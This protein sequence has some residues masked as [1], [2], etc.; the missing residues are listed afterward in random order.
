MGNTVRPFREESWTIKTTKTKKRKVVRHISADMEGRKLEEPFAISQ[1]SL[2]RDISIDNTT[3]VSSMDNIRTMTTVVAADRLRKTLKALEK[4]IYPTMEE[5]QR[6]LTSIT[7]ILDSL[8]TS[9]EERFLLSRHSTS[10]NRNPGFSECVPKEVQKWLTATFTTQYQITRN[11]GR[12]QR[13]FKDVIC[14]VKC[15]LYVEKIYKEVCGVRIPSNVESLIKTIDEWTCD[16]LEVD[17]A[18]GEH[19]LRFV[20]FEIF[21]KYEIITKF[22]ISSGILDHFLHVVQIGYRK[23][24]NAYHNHCHAA[25]VL[26]TVHYMLSKLEI[27]TAYTDLQIFAFLFAAVIHDYEHTGKTN[28]Y[29][30]KARSELAMLYNDRSVQENHH[31][32]AAFSLLSRQEINILA[33]LSAVEYSNFRTLVIDMVLGTDMSLHFEQMKTLK[34]SLVNQ[35]VSSFDPTKSMPFLLHCADICHPAK[36][37]S[38]HKKWTDRVMDEFFQQGDAEKAQGLPFSPLCDR[39]TTVI[40]ESQVGFISII[41]SPALDICGDVVDRLNQVG[42]EKSQSDLKLRQARTPRDSIK[43]AISISDNF[44]KKQHLTPRVWTKHLQANRKR[45]QDLCYTD[46]QKDNT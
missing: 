34:A 26:Q 12:Q 37:W 39:N 46:I 38:V 22:N 10:D 16:V 45:W 21:N 1:S 33:N 17:R 25:E 43:I 27:A 32:S 23:Y 8:S 7:R 6:Q 35:D 42:Q 44:E 5:L 3:R 29:H 20:G 19:A 40:P 13:K 36:E 28:L 2:T 30:I 18:S 15:S 31:I 11:L 24:P 4:G 14:A 41:L 9:D